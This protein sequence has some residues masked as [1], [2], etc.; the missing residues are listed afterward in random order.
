MTGIHLKKTSPEI[1]AMKRMEKTQNY[2]AGVLVF[3]RRT[4]V[5]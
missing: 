1:I 4:M 5:L 3:R 2:N